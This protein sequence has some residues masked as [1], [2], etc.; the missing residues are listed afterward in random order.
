[1]SL[2]SKG[3]VWRQEEL[4]NSVLIRGHPLF[5]WCVHV[6]KCC[7][8]T[9]THTHV[10][11]C[12]VGILKSS[13]WAGCLPPSFLSLLS[14]RLPPS[15]P[16]SLSILSF[17]FLSLFLHLSL[18][19]SLPL[20]VCACVCVHV[21]LCVAELTSQKGRIVYLV[22]KQLCLVPTTRAHLYTY[23]MYSCNTW[24]VVLCCCHMLNYYG[25]R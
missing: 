14:L 6:V 20:C 22:M 7:T 13:A 2:L 4:I 21:R 25:D 23:S 1:M 5:S 12:V 11:A 19:P 15:P 10:H 24:K 9:H 8:H 16:L 3:L 17:S 18:P